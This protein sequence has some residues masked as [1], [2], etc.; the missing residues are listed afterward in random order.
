MCGEGG[1]RGR[2]GGRRG[3]GEEVG[4]GCG[5]GACACVWCVWWVVVVV[6]LTVCLTCV[7]VHIRQ[8]D[9]PNYGS[10]VPVNVTPSALHLC[11]GSPKL[12]IS[13]PG[14]TSRLHSCTVRTC[15]CC[16]TETTRPDRRTATAGL[17]CFLHVHTGHLS[18]TTTGKSTSLSKQEV[19]QF[20][21]FV[22][23]F[24]CEAATKPSD[25]S[26]D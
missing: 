7:F 4:V 3:E 9:A 21:L 24:C 22:S 5:V 1:E 13:C 8:R 12:P 6:V 2:E 18:S 10:H 15:L 16:Q 26:V 25:T 19:A 17:H 20:A 11:A 23:V 14:D